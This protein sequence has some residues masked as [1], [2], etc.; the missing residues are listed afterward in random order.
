MTTLAHGVHY[1]LVLGG[2]LGITLLLGPQLLARSRARRSLPAHAPVDVHERRVALLRAGLAAG[3]LT[4]SP[5]DVLLVDPGPASPP[6]AGSRTA[7]PLAAVASAAAAGIHAAVAPG[8][9]QDRVAVGAFFVV[10]TAAQLLWAA[11]LL[12]GATPSLLLAGLVGNAAVLALW[13]ASRTVGVGALPHGQGSF[14]PWD[15][16]CAAFELVVVGVC[17]TRIAHGGAREAVAPWDTWTPTVRSL[18][19]AAVLALGVLSLSG[20]AA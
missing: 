10:V 5:A 7:L 12:R 9:L 6:V 16:T 19:V 11:L 3:T 18:L 4:R 15:L 8:H 2:L 20:A 1:G 14:G 13:L 17:V